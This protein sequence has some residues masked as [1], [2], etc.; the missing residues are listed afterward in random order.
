[1]AALQELIALG[2]DMGFEG[3]ELQQFVAEQQQAER[4]ERQKRREAE[5]EA[6]EAEQARREAEQAMEERK[7]R[8]TLEHEMKAKELELEARLKEVQ[9]G[10][11]QGANAADADRGGGARMSTPKMPRIPEFKDGKDSIDAYIERFER[12]ATQ[13]GWSRDTWSVALS[14][15]LTGKALD[16]YARMDSQDALDFG[17][18]KKALLDRYELNA[19]GFR[20]RLRESGPDEMENPHQYLTRLGNYLNK[21]VDMTGVPQTVDGIKDL[22]VM[23]QFV[24]TYSLDLATFLK[25]RSC[26]TVDELAEQSSRYLDAHGKQLRDACRKGGR[27]VA[28]PATFPRLFCAKC[29]TT[30]HNTESCRRVSSP[31]VK[32]KDDRHCFYCYKPGHVMQSCPKLRLDQGK[33]KAGAGETSHDSTQEGRA[34]VQCWRCGRKGHIARNC[35]AQRTGRAQQSGK[36]Q[37]GAGAEER[38]MSGCCQF[39]ECAGEG[40]ELCNCV[41]GDRVSLACG[42]SLTVVQCSNGTLSGGCLLYTSDAADE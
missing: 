5:R 1:M 35:F 42:R 23:E 19:E 16:V 36:V 13:N 8:L 22:I 29:Q 40:G 27:K 18:L 41:K 39:A 14:A 12:I 3:K 21:W 33:L 4:D 34:T 26:K 31:E 20:K 10:G 28:T 17:K 11:A 2:K 6:R 38:E 9:L 32:K 30:T 15:L 7:L 24:Q 25:E 37:Q